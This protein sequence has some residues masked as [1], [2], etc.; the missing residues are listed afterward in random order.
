M[1]FFFG[2]VKIHSCFSWFSVDNITFKLPCKPF[3]LYFFSLLCFCPPSGIKLIYLLCIILSG[4]STAYGAEKS[5][6]VVRQ[7][8]SNCCTSVYHWGYFAFFR[9]YSGLSAMLRHY[10]FSFK[11]TSFIFSNVFKFSVFYWLHPALSLVVLEWSNFLELALD[12]KCLR[13]TALQ[14]FL[15]YTLSQP[16]F[17]AN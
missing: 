3:T 2:P 13:T 10:S 8:F 12:V 1:R 7:W 6:N 17:K 16:T 9:L 14:N 11:M 5:V 15:F 4:L